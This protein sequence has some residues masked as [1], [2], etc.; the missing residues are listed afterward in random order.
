MAGFYKANN[1]DTNKPCKRDN[2]GPK[3]CHDRYFP[4]LFFTARCEPIPLPTR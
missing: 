4:C 2:A 3:T 1:P